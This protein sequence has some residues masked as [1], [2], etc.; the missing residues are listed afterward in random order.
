[1]NDRYIKKARRCTAQNGGTKS[2]N[3]GEWLLTLR[4]QL[5]Q[6]IEGELEV[7]SFE[8]D[9]EINGET[10]QIVNESPKYFE[11]RGEV[12]NHRVQKT[13]QSDAKLPQQKGRRIPGQL[14]KTVD[15]EISMLLK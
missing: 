1:M 11:R 2:I 13:L 5:N 6:E 3:S 9:Q 10:K 8:K 14:Q 7:I 12:K 4:N 15:E